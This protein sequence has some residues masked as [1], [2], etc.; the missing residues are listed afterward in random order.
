MN[1]KPL[2]ILIVDDREDDALLL[3]REL[4]KNG[5]NPDY[6]RVDNPTDMNSTLDNEKFDIV[7]SDFAMPNFTGLD[8]LKIFKSKSLYIPF[9]LISG[10]IGEDVAVQAI[11]AGAND[12]LLKNNLTRLSNIIIRELDVAESNRKRI[13]TEKLLSKAEQKYRDLVES[14]PMLF[15]TG[16]FNPYPVPTYVSPQV[17]DFF[18]YTMQEFLSDPEKFM[19]HIHKDDS[20][21]ILKT[22]SETLPKGEVYNAQFRITTRDGKI[23][24]IKDH[25]F[26]IIDSDGKAQEFRGFAIDITAQKQLE[27][28]FVQLQKMDS[29]SKLAGGIT[30]DFNNMLTVI[31]G[32]AQLIN[33]Q[34]DENDPN[35]DSVKEI[36]QASERAANLTH[37]L[38]IF[39]RKQPITPRSLNMNS[40]ISDLQKMFKRLVPE[41]ITI[42][43][44][45]E[46]ALG[47][48]K[49]D[50]VQI[51]QV[52]MNLVVNARDAMQKGGTLTIETKNVFIDENYSKRYIGIKD[53]QYVNICVSDTGI[54]MDDNVKSHLF[55]PFFT[56]KGKGT[57]LGLAT[58]Y[59]IIKQN[60]GFINVYS[61]P[62][63]GTTF[64]IYLPRTE[65]ET[66]TIEK[67]EMIKRQTKQ[68]SETVLIAED[69]ESIRV[70]IN[71]VLLSNGYKVLEAKSG[72]GA[73]EVS[74]EFKGDIDLLITDMVMP[75]INGV[76]LYN[77][78]KSVRPNLKVVFMSGYTEEAAIQCGELEKGS[79]FLS[80]PFNT[81][82]LLNKI[83]DVLTGR[84]G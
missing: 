23:K 76:E 7:V 29:M 39:S 55:E 61:E 49:A 40:V 18:G 9:I 22:L 78:L 73:I 12:Y 8:A 82:D 14:L 16:K 26:P 50:P 65:D 69:E 11:K 31:K 34:M 21:R 58:V 62:E 68:G 28:Q 47:K 63:K 66:T 33:M 42:T 77:K 1:N 19:K 60:N 4:K 51:E 17:K 71:K 75:G 70:L 10:A 72:E 38:L 64:R 48:I 79:A 46:P 45:L 41:D 5:F 37:Q 20:S 53:G 43:A 35:R 52:I 80:K 74:G 30:H 36:I 83:R 32:F 81:D 44:V 24:W 25:A 2:K 54:G 59:G 84:G 6:K 56:T 3:I 15:Y 27:E 67:S 57:G 13:E